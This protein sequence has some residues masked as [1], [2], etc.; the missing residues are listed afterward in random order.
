[1]GV[2]VMD[3]GEGVGRGRET[4]WKRKKDISKNSSRNGEVGLG[5]LQQRASR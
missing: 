3:Q 2:E 5:N 4:N 1:M